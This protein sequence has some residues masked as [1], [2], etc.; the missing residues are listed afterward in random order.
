MTVLAKIGILEIAFSAVLLPILLFEPVQK[1]IVK[2]K[3]QLLSAHLD[4][5][6]MGILLILA[7]TVLGPIPGW[8]A[9]PMVIGGI[10]NPSVFAMNSVKPE[11]PQNPI[12]RAFVLLSCGCVAFA[13][14]AMGVRAILM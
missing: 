4:Y 12:Y 13:W 10:A 11:L 9:V 6:F 7:G 2:D 1:H 3:N 5:F 8:I 14:G